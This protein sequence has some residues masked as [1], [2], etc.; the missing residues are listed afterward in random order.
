MFPGLVVGIRHLPNIEDHEDLQR[1]Q[2]AQDGQGFPELLE[3][4]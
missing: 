1:F 2:H 4:G 3:V